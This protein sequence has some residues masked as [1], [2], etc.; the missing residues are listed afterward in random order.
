MNI[1]FSFLSMENITH[2]LSQKYQI[3]YYYVIFRLLMLMIFR[4]LRSEMV[5]KLG[6]RVL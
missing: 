4:E 2:Q 3:I 5:S 6:A 1:T